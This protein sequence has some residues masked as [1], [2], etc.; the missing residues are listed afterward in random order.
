MNIGDVLNIQFK[1][2]SIRASFA[3]NKRT[4]IFPAQN[5]LKSYQNRANCIANKIVPYSDFLGMHSFRT[6]I[7]FR[8]D[9]AGNERSFICNNKWGKLTLRQVVRRASTNEIH[10]ANLKPFKFSR[11]I[12]LRYYISRDKKKEKKKRIETKEENSRAN[13]IR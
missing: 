4:A 6:Q 12:T 1:W 7:T 2:N 10:F 9:W 13:F 8:S 5:S 3:S 11:Q